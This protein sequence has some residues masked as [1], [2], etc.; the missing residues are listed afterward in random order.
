MNPPERAKRGFGA[1]S[2]EKR[3]EL[4]RKGGKAVPP[5]ERGFAKDRELA[6]AA[7]REGGRKSKRRPATT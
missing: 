6:A 3:R 5:S 7:G 1:M 2:P 4:A